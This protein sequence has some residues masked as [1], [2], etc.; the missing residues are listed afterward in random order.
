MAVNASAADGI[1]KNRK[2]ENMIQTKYIKLLPT[3]RLIFRRDARIV[4]E[5]NRF[6]LKGKSPW[7]YEGFYNPRGI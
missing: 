1:R 7:T 3:L 6:V 4:R 5:N 2:G